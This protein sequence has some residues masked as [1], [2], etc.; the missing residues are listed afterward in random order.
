MSHC[1]RNDTL[2]LASLGSGGVDVDGEGDVVAEF[3]PGGVGAD[4]Y[5]FELGSPLLG[6]ED[7]VDVIAAVFV[8]PEIVSG[9]SLFAL[10]FGE[11]MMVGG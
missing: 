10:G 2:K 7:V 9:L 3:G 11:E 1:A 5:A 6:E 8:V 4:F